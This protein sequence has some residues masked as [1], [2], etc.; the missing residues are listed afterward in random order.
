MDEGSN[1]VGWRA[2]GPTGIEAADS[3]WQLGSV[4][5]IETTVGICCSADGSDKKIEDAETIKMI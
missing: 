1:W 5:L 4:P 3:S 2:V